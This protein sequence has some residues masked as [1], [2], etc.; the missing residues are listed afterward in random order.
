MGEG[1]QKALD[2]CE[3]I[4]EDRHASWT[5]IQSRGKG[6]K[7]LDSFGVVTSDNRSKSFAGYLMLC[8]RQEPPP[9]KQFRGFFFAP[10]TQGELHAP[11]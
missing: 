7:P 8:S 1:K 3:M 10:S 5:G 11:E 4:S 9:P 2:R 6:E